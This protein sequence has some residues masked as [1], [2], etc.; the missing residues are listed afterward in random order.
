VH[1]VTR[2]WETRATA[3]IGDGMGRVAGIHFNRRFVMR[4]GREATHPGKLNPDIV[5]PAGPVDEMIGLLA[6]RDSSEKLLGLVVNFGCHCT[7]TE[8]GS[9]YSADYVHYLREHLKR[10]L[11]PLPVVFLL[12]ACGDVTQID[13]QSAGREKGHAWADTMGATLAAEAARVV[14]RMQ[15]RDAAKI[16]ATTEDFTVT[17]RG[18]DAAPSATVGLGSGA[19]W[20]EIYARERNFVAEMRRANPTV[21]CHVTALR[22]GGLAIVAN[23][24]ELF[25]QPSLDIKAASPVQRTWVVTLA[26]EYLGYIPTAAAHR[27]GG[28]EVRTARSSFLDIDAAEK[29]VAA[30]LAALN[31]AGSMSGDER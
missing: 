18:K 28:Y 30:S 7:V 5:R 4:N 14:M 22:I 1:A 17:I 15:W 23:G 6:A 10:L 8:D 31:R 24:G 27:A 12:G 26:N 25:C 9:E 19:E 3:Q 13:N 16:T 29:I 2:A 11:A 20:E 21:E